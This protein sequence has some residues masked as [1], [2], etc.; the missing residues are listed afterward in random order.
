MTRS[1][2]DAANTTARTSAMAPW[3]GLNTCMETMRP[4]TGQQI[5]ANRASKRHPCAHPF[6]LRPTPS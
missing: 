2:A 6:L 5:L 3:P 1:A 4:V